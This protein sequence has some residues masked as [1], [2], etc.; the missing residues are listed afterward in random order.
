[1]LQISVEPAVALIDVERRI[2]ISGAKPQAKVTLKTQTKRAGH[3]WTSEA[4][5]EAD[6][7]GA[8]D[9]TRDAPVS[10]TYQG[11]SA[12]GLIWSQN[13]SEQGMFP[14]FHPDLSRAL[15]TTITASSGDDSSDALLVQTLMTEGVIRE[16]VRVNGLVGTLYRAAGS[17]ARPAVMIMNGSGGG[18]NEP[19]AALYASRGYHALAL[20]YFGAEGLPKYISNTPLEYFEKGLDWLRDAVKPKDDFVAISGQSRG[21]ELVL[22]LG[23]TYPQK[24]SAVIGYVPSAFVHGGQAAADPALGRDGPCWLYQG[25]PLTHIWDNNRFASWKPYDD[26]TQPR[27]N[28]AAMR[29]ALADP[30]AMRKARIPVEKIAG[31]VMLISGGDDGAWPSDYYSLLVQSSLLAAKHAFPVAWYNH[32]QAGHSILFPYVPA[33]QIVHAHPVNGNLTTMGG[34]ADVNAQANAASWQ[35]VLQF[36]S[37]A[38]V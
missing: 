10:G 7:Q 11:V 1:M 35:A 16:E 26:G 38:T 21:G 31:P 36:L 20:G 9:L 22:L 4:V 17:E 5:F 8:I 33:T 18:V 29:T 12:M 3:D 15:E 6:A 25:K 28:S 32:P 23:A 34:E 2:T 37:Q 24:V 30:E 19:R 14:L 27:R 13:H